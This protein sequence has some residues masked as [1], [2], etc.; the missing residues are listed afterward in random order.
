MQLQTRTWPGFRSVP[1]TL[2]FDV[3]SNEICARW[4]VTGSLPDCRRSKDSAHNVTRHDKPKE[5]EW[6]AQAED[7]NKSQQPPAGNV[8][9]ESLHC[10][11]VALADKNELGVWLCINAH[12]GPFHISS[13]AR[14]LLLFLL[15]SLVL[16]LP[17]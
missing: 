2:G 6:K 9:L 1:M 17:Y 3:G 12:L 4:W 15:F 11:S 8:S 10:R 14:R 5:K 16:L 13:L 7:W